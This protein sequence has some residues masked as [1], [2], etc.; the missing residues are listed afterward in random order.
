MTLENVI[1][2]AKSS[3]RTNRSNSEEIARTDS[4]RMTEK[5]ERRVVDI[6]T[7]EGGVF[8]ERRFGDILSDGRE[9]GTKSV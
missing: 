7:D 8:E 6:E 9:R 3:E 4:E 5:H 2:D 1:V